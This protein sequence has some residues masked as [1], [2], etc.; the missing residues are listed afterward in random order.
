MHIRA[1]GRDIRLGLAMVAGQDLSSYPPLELEVALDGVGATRREVASS[2]DGTLRVYLGSG[3]FAA[4]G[5]DL[6]FSDFLT[7]LFTR[8]NPFS[9]N[10]K[11]THLDCAVM[12]ADAV[13]GKVDVLPIIFN[14]T[15]LTILSHGSVDLDSEKIHLSFNT[16]ARKGI[17][18]TAGVLINPLIKVGGRL[19]APHVEVDPAGTLRSGG[20]AV[21]TIGI[22]VLAKT[23]TDRFF[24]SK[25]PCGDARKAIDKRDSASP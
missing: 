3:Q 25:D 19:T 24:S 8:L 7:Q 2:L 4:A 21:A 16:K 18:I 20:L 17:G 12:A 15:Q 5:L 11:Y 10:S 9:K 1:H 23:V 14:T 22:S 6:L 13:S